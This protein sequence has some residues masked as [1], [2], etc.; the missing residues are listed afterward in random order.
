MKIYKLQIWLDGDEEKGES[1]EFRDLYFDVT[2][3]TGWFIPNKNDDMPDSEAINIFFDGDIIT[4]KQESHI[5]KYLS[6][7]FG[8]NAIKP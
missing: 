3:I 4:I 8:H 1:P 6:E 7:N 5:L 2:K